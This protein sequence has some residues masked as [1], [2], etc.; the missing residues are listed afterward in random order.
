MGQY[1][2]QTKHSEM[3][4]I[5][6]RIREAAVPKR[7]LSTYIMNKIGENEMSRVTRTRGSNAKPSIFK[8][9]A[10][11]AA[12]AGVLGAG[13]IGAGFVSPV[14]AETLKKIPGFG[15]IFSGTSDAAVEEAI[16]QGIISE[17]GQSVT[18]D[19]ITLKLINLLYDGTRLSF[20]IDRDGAP[21]EA[22]TLSLP[23]ALRDTPEDQLPKG[24][25][26][27]PVLL[28]NG[29]EA[30]PIT[31]GSY[32][33]YVSKGDKN[34]YYSV[35]WNDVNLP[36]EFELTVQAKVSR[37]AETFE[38]K[39][40]VKL[41]QRAVVL[42]PNI[43][44]DNG[45]FS[46]TV[47]EL[48]LSPVTTRLV[49]DSEGPVPQSPEQTGDYHASMVYYEIVDDQG[50]ELEQVRFGYWNQKPKT[51]Y[52]VNE[53]F[54]PLDSTT[55]SITIKPFTL[56]VKND[57]WSVVGLVEDSKGNLSAGQESN[58]GT[59]TYLKDLEVTIPINQ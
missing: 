30:A 4:A 40:P 9:T 17:P 20:L 39:V 42:N 3:D 1:Q 45:S 29:Q 52:Q 58:R 25:L 57:D 7:E 51:Q 19:G 21:A 33:D 43:S 24:Y 26:D 50:N 13:T 14:M 16:Q 38:F 8:K 34:V 37:V 46:Y 31:S 28:V 48:H 22:E 5:E 53:L 54:P 36:D 27:H 11:A 12:V 23:W 10:I 55:K 41:D 18:H 47:K 35:D 32:G 6:Q 56:T 15:V 2:R 44:K 49:L 59:R